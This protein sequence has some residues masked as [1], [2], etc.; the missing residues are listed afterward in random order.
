MVDGSGRCDGVEELIYGGSLMSMRVV[1]RP[2][3]CWWGGQ[4]RPV[5]LHR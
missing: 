3:H 1:K 5:C 4:G 2:I